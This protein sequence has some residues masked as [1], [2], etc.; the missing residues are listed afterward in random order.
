MTKMEIVQ[1]MLAIDFSSISD[2]L[3]KLMEEGRITSGARYYVYNPYQIYSLTWLQELLDKA[4]KSKNYIRCI[5]RTDSITFSIIW[6]S[7]Q[8]DLNKIISFVEE[9]ENLPFEQT[10]KQILIQN[11]ELE[12]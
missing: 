1:E 12:N 8:E 4:G 5:K 9:Q 3:D 2:R 7:F 10:Q 6:K 11:G